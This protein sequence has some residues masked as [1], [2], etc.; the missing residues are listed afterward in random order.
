MQNKGYV[1]DAIL[2]KENEQ[3]CGWEEERSSE[4]GLMYEA[5]ATI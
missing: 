5:A 1:V 4:I 2:E 3:N